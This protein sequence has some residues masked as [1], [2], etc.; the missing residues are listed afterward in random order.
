MASENKVLKG[1]RDVFGEHSEKKRAILNAL[2]EAFTVYGYKYL[3]TPH[4]EMLSTLTS[5]FAGGEEIIDEIFKLTDRGKRSLA[6]RYDHTVPLTRFV[7]EHPELSTPYKRYAI[8][9]V[10]RDGPIKKGRLREFSQA[11]ADIVGVKGP[12][13]EL[14]LLSLAQSV[15]Q[16]LEI[17]AVIKIN[18]KVLLESLLELSGVKKEDYEG[19]MLSIDKLEKIGKEKVSEELSEKKVSQ[20]AIKRLFMLLELCGGK[21][22][23]HVMQILLDEN[24]KADTRKNIE[25]SIRQVEF[26]ISSIENAELEITLARGLNYYTGMLFEA[27]MQKSDMK[28]SIAAGGRYKSI[29]SRDASQECSGISFGIDAILEA[30]ISSTGIKKPRVFIVPVKEFRE[31]FEVAKILRKENIICGID[32]LDR[33]MTKNIKYASSNGYNYVL[34]VGKKEIEE[35]KY[36]LKNLETGK[37]EKLEL[38][39]VVRYFAFE[40]L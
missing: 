11:D 23:S 40:T 35:G 34:I 7:S 19:V 26:V 22:P 16:S 21:K 32:L 24:P 28:S 29:F 27:F 31:A 33:G 18:H 25:S 6:L 39:K 13:A 1:T 14:E 2:Q 9:S 30:G 8:G 10:F 12:E 3:E 17:N 15:F 20:E 38:E 37:E 4:I 5:K 36:T